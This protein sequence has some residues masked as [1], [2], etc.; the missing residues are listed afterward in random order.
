MIASPK[1]FSCTEAARVQPEGPDLPAHDAVT[2]LLTRL[3]PDPQT[4]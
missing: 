2:R 3:E 4:L 1:H